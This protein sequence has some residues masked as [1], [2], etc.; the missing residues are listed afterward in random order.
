VPH[1]IR[2]LSYGHGGIFPDPL[3]I[4]MY[5]LFDDRTGGFRCLGP[6][7]CQLHGAIDW[8]EGGL[9]NARPGKFYY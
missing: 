6:P 1:D 4:L 2:W 7:A 8:K 5:H 9:H 3:W